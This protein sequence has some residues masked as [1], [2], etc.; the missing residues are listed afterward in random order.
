MD[1]NL[2]AHG[3]A[4]VFQPLNLLVLVGGS[5]AGIIVGAIPG[6][7]ATMAI[8]IMVPFT[9][10]LNPVTG[11]VMLLGI[12]AGAIYGG[13][14]P[15]ILVRTPGTPA[16]AA[17]VLDGYPLAQ[18]GMAGKA[19]GMATISSFIGGGSTAIFLTF[20]APQLAKVALRFGSPE[21]FAMAVFGLSLVATLAGD[22]MVKGLISATAGLLISLIGMDPV[23][24]FPRFTFGQIELLNGPAFVPVLIGLFAVAECFRGFGEMRAVAAARTVVREVIPTLKEMLECSRTIGRGIFVGLIVGLVPALGAETSCW[25]NYAESKRAS[26]HP[27]RFGTGILEGV[28]A[29][30]TANNASTG[31]DM[32]PM[33]TLGVPGD[34]ATAVLMGALTIHGMQPGPL[35]FRDHADVVYA[36]FAGMIMANVAFLV[37]GLLGVRLFAAVV[38][39]N[40]TILI[41]S[42][43]VFSVI[44]AYAVNGNM[45]DVLVTIIFGFLGYLMQSRG[46]PV[47]PMVIAQVLGPMMEQN[48]RRAL[49]ANNG[50]FTV[51]VRKPIAASILLLT[52]FTVYTAL[53]RQQQVRKLRQ[54]S[55]AA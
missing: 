7:T 50:D 55:A 22:S 31:G 30:E 5:L 9:F 48:F 8:A 18:K 10:D 33:L 42:I 19:I 51:F 1:W 34:A 43:F 13:S 15:A 21:F 45:F 47:S 40:R 4:T 37:L 16:A 32:V 54:A 14:I 38:N 35:L 52:V 25:M 53:R 27:E 39:V 26:K 2:L 6:L 36:I 12:Y 11:I 44:G 41:P 28:A 17:T 3:F 49:I 29:S 46:Y 20:F 24:G 23:S